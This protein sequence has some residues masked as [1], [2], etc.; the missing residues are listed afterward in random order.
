MTAAN[1]RLL[2]VIGKGGVGRSTTAA[3][4]AQQAARNGLRALAI[5]ATATGG[6]ALALGHQQRPKPG[7]PMELSD[8]AVTM[9]ELGTEAALDEYVRLT[10]RIPIAPRS[11]GPIARIFDYVATAA[12]AVREILTIGKIAHEVRRGP[13][14][15][16][17]V[18]GP[19]T[20]HVIEL[21]AAPDA[22]GEL[23]GRGP[24]V[25]EAHWISA[26]L[27]D[28]AV[29]SAIPVTLAEELPVT[30]TVELVARLRA[31]TR[32]HAGGLV[33]NRVPPVVSEAGQREAAQLVARHDPLA[34]LAV[35]AVERDRRAQTE[36]GRLDP[37]DL[38]RV[39]VADTPG[40]PVE[41]MAGALAAT[42]WWLR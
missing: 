32:V 6:L 42:G 36:L 9:V 21:L 38:A 26:L 29:T 4:L 18:D 33:V 40:N 2:I 16:V 3:A 20:G 7:R 14:D 24:L 27:A 8:P 5:D 12:P 13:W 30:E 17:V 41:A 37:L 10:L 34:Q 28:P 15:V 23:V 35:V 31:E 19:A 11:L 1:A 22:L 25:D 39:T